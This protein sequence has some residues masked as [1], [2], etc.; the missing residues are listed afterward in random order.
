MSTRAIKNIRTNAFF[1]EMDTRERG[2][3]GRL[4]FRAKAV[5]SSDKPIIKQV[6]PIIL[7][8]KVPTIK[9]IKANNIKNWIR[10]SILPAM[11]FSFNP[12]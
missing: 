10:V 5:K 1:I 8:I 6:N 12:I 9:N 3:V 7:P 2:F 11:C 4:K